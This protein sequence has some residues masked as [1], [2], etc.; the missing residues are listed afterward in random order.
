MDVGVSDSI[1]IPRRPAVHNASRD[2]TRLEA[3]YR[4]GYDETRAI[5][6]GL[7]WPGLLVTA[8]LKA[9]ASV[10]RSAS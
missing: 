2:L 4:Q 8:A 1:P 3:L 10:S 7:E 6:I 9:R 5:S